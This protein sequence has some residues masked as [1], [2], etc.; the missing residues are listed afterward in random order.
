VSRTLRFVWRNFEES[1]LDDY[2]VKPVFKALEVF[3]T[4]CE[5]S[6]PMSLNE[7]SRATSLPK[8]TVF[9]YLYT[10]QATSLVEF[11]PASET[12]RTGL[13]LWRLSR[14]NSVYDSL[15]GLCLPELRKLQEEFN[16]T[17]NLGVLSAGEIVYLEI[18]ASERPLRM[19]IKAGA[20]DA[21]HSTALGKAMLAFRPRE[22]QEN[23]LALPLRAR[24]ANTITDPTRLFRQLAEI[25]D[26]GFAFDRGENEQGSICVATPILADGTSV[27]AISVSAPDQRIDAKTLKRICASLARSRASIE[28]RVARS[29][30]KPRVLLR[31]TGDSVAGAPRR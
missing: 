22:Q 7:I 11:D 24:T 29:I 9:R 17:V 26:S 30:D 14:A 12:Y 13:S 19:Q 28:D 20:T 6:G 21:V 8:T 27:A 2:L 1:S 18:V 4:V 5:A 10:L 16:E 23:L 31:T 3:R 25:H 15:R